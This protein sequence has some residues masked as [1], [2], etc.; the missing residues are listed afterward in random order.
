MGI[1]GARW[2]LGLYGLV[3]LQLSDLAPTTAAAVHDPLDTVCPLFHGARWLLGLYGLVLL[4]QLGDLAPTPVIV[5][6]VQPCPLF[7]VPG[8]HRP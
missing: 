4:L 6:V 8:G 2:L 5:V 3:L 7:M 1:Y